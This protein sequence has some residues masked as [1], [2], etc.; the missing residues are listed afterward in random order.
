MKK[1]TGDT[2]NTSTNKIKIPTVNERLG[3]RFFL[4]S[5]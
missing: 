4:L 2:A 1:M 3:K 5:W